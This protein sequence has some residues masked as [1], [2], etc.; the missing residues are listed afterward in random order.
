MLYAEKARQDFEV[1]RKPQRSSENRCTVRDKILI[2]AFRTQTR[3]E[4]SS[5]LIKDNP[6][7]VGHSSVVA[8]GA[9]CDKEPERK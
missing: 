1:K 3:K 2:F 5:F 7:L 4:T 6:P 8:E 9:S